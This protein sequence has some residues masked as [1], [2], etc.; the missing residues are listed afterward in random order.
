[1]RL[2]NNSLIGITHAKNSISAQEEVITEADFEKNIAYS[3]S[4]NVSPIDFSNSLVS[5]EGTSLSIVGDK[6]KYN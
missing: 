6:Q 1:M 3:L 4:Q 5:T 2:N